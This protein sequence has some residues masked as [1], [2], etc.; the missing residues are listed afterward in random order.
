M[1]IKNISIVLTVLLV[2]IAALVL[3]QKGNYVD[4]ATEHY[5][6]T[7]EASFKGGQKIL[8]YVNNSV[9]VNKLVWAMA[10][11]ANQTVK[12]S[13]DMA[14][15]EAKYFP[16]TKGSNNIGQK[17]RRFEATSAYVIVSTFDKVDVDKKTDLKT[18]SGLKSIDVSALI[19]EPLAAETEEVEGEEEEDEEEVAEE[20]PAPEPKKAAKGKKGKKGKKR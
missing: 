6:K 4:Q 19:G 16:T 1:N 11:E 2:F 13:Q 9:D 20:A 18:L 7:T 17:T 10:V 12:T 8:E 5:T 14:R 15:L 3:M